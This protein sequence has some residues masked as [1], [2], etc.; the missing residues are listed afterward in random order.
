[1][2]ISDWLDEKEKEKVDLSQIELPKIWLTMKILMKLSFS[3]R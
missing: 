1:M 2:K 3:K